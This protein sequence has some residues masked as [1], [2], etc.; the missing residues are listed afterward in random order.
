MAIPGS[1]LD[2]RSKGCNKLLREGAILVEH[3]GDVIDVIKTVF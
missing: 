2:P 3:A 1:P